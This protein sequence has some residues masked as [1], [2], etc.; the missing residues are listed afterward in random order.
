MEQT[1]PDT[2]VNRLGGEPHIDHDTR[3]NLALVLDL[4]NQTDR[5]YE[6]AHSETIDE[7]RFLDHF[8]AKI[9]AATEERLRGGNLPN[10][11]SNRDP[12]EQ[13]RYLAATR[14][15]DVRLA[16][17]VIYTFYDSVGDGESRQ[18]LVRNNRELTP[19]TI[20]SGI[21]SVVAR[22]LASRYQD[23]MPPTIN[24]RRSDGIA[25][26]S[27][28]Y[29]S[30]DQGEGWLQSL[31]DEVVTVVNERERLRLRLKK[32]LIPEQEYKAGVTS[33]N[34]DSEMRA[35]RSLEADAGIGAVEGD[36]GEEEPQID[37]AEEF[38]QR[39][40]TR[41]VVGE[42]TLGGADPVL[43]INEAL[44]IVGGE[45]AEDSKRGHGGEKVAEE[46]PDELNVVAALVGEAHRRRAPDA[47]DLRDVTETV[48][49]LAA[50]VRPDED[51]AAEL[52]AA[53]NDGKTDDLLKEDRADVLDLGWYRSS[54][55]SVDDAADSTEA[56]PTAVT[57]SVVAAAT[58]RSAA[59]VATSGLG[60]YPPPAHRLATDSS[61]P[62]AR[63]EP[64]TKPFETIR[65]DEIYEDIDATVDTEE[66]NRYEVEAD[67]AELRTAR[68]AEQKSLANDSRIFGP[69]QIALAV[70][71][72]DAT[73][74]GQQTRGLNPNFTN[75]ANAVM[76]RIDAVIGNQR[77]AA[78]GASSNAP[79][80]LTQRA[81]EA[82][83]TEQVN[84]AVP[85]ARVAERVFGLLNRG[86]R[87]ALDLRREQTHAAV[88][89]MVLGPIQ[90]KYP[91]EEAQSYTMAA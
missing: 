90:A 72:Y 33:V 41:K 47:T 21:N 27:E 16:E 81:I 32:M 85:G 55:G 35:R 4:S 20:V 15:D 91:Q 71:E 31:P 7:D 65:S 60:G 38:I 45:A 44:R 50:E 1:R 12:E 64:L 8:T 80:G 24:G 25:A 51:V 87:R 17:E 14:G 82:L 28:L 53:L 77:S 30:P 61:S 78:Y 34:F 3:G 9:K 88:R 57:G 68:L 5:A 40:E 23:K 46:R 76:A 86:R 66:L 69:E 52:T 49:G 62:N 89:K 75:V 58:A 39:E 70:E 11:L 29:P 43:E 83:I 48:S 54:E 37:L 56:D 59:P 79:I 22:E 13:A 67:T 26:I 6:R 19:A 18:E 36:D 2:G 10:D 63:G 74:E 84:Q 42:L 73:L